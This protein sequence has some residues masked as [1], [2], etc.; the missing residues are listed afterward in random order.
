VLKQERRVGPSS[1]LLFHYHSYPRILIETNNIKCADHQSKLF[2]FIEIYEIV[3]LL[4]YSSWNN[5]IAME[6]EIPHLV[7]VIV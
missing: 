7:D 5:L 1:G 6:S 2:L 3:T 4:E